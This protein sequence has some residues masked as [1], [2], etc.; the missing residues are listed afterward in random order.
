M[1]EEKS[2]RYSDESELTNWK[3]NVLSGYAPRVGRDQG[4]KE[5]SGAS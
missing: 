4:D 5:K 2:V 3:C 1:D